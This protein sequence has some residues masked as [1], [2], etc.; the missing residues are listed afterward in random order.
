MRGNVSNVAPVL[1]IVVTMWVLFRNLTCG[2]A[3]FVA[4]KVFLVFA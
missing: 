4:G 1:V 3:K 2:E